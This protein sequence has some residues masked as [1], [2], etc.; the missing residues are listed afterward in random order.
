MPI[1][2]LLA[3]M[4]SLSKVRRPLT[5]PLAMVDGYSA[6]M[7]VLPGP[8]VEDLQPIWSQLHLE[9]RAMACRLAAPIWTGAAAPLEVAGHAQ[10]DAAA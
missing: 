3:V 2:T 10:A 8:V 5:F 4:V 7:A 1:G 6:G 9:L